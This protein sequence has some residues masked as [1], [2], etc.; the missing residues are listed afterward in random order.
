MPAPIANKNAATHGAYSYLALGSLPKGA[1]YIRRLTGKLR[2]QLTQAV[3]DTGRTAGVM[4]AAWIN[5]A[6]RHEG[7]AQLLQRYLRLEDLPITLRIQLLKEIG[8]ATS[9]R[10]RAI[11]R[12]D[13][14]RAP[15]APW[16]MTFDDPAGS[17]IDAVDGA[18]RALI[19]GA[20]G[21]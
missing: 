21:G 12:L 11:E 6:C 17:A 4:E 3:Q 15:L 16:E 14:R 1:S 10:D 5:S 18:E 2:I 8:F 13:L 7:R 19:E 9:A 20:V